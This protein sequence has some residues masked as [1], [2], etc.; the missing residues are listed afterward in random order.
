MKFDLDIEYGC[1]ESSQINF[2]RPSKIKHLHWD[3]FTVSTYFAYFRPKKGF[4]FTFSDYMLE[5][6]N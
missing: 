6:L 2:K 5:I 4:K 3:I 1:L